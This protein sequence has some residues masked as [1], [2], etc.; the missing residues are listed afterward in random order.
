MSLRFKRVRI[1]SL[2]AV[3]YIL[4]IFSDNFKWYLLFHTVLFPL[5]CL[6]ADLMSDRNEFYLNTYFNNILLFKGCHY[7]VAFH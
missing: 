3:E 4:I 6:G 7:T 5:P 2:S 1:E